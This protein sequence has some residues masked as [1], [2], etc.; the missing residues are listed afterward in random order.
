VKF[1]LASALFLSAAA[2]LPAD[3]VWVAIFG[4]NDLTISMFGLSGSFDCYQS[5]AASAACSV[6]YT[7]PNGLY[8]GFGTASATTSFGSISGQAQG[9]EDKLVSS[10]IFASYYA[11]FANDVVVTGGTGKGTLIAQYQLTASSLQ[12]V[13]PMLYPNYPLP[14]PT[15]TLVQGSTK[16][17]FDTSLTAANSY[18]DEQF[19]VT[20]P[21]QFGIPFAFG[22]ETQ[23]SIGAGQGAETGS[24]VK[25]TGFEVLDSS[26]NIVADAQ[27]I[28]GQ[29]LGTGIF[30]PEPLPASLVLLGFA[31][32]LWPAAR[33]RG[34]S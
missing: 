24:G 14:S 15:F 8:E 5:G 16:D 7:S 21:F 28:P 2:Y 6:S 31:A 12:T 32:L 19:D 30:T 9:G 3:P 27:L 23:A 11:S 26:G 34:G 18:I 25:L 29:A 13:D 1:L 33:H 17:Y 20:S 22:A 10:L 4:P